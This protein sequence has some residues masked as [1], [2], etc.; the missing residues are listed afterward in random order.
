MKIDVELK[1][2]V[3]VCTYNSARYL[4]ACLESIINN[5]PVNTLW[6]I[7]KYSTDR[8]VEIAKRYGAK[9]VQTH[10]RRIR[11]CGGWQRRLH[12]SLR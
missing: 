1:V 3:M 11:R 5:I 8:T 9:I 10:L 6:I 2:D 7:D 12:Q 4:D